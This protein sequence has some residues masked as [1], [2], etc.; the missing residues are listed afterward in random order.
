M[1]QTPVL[2]PQLENQPLQGHWTYEDY[3]NLPDDGRRYEIIDGVLYVTNAP[4]RDHQYTVVRL[5]YQLLQFVESRG[6]GEILTA[7]FEVHLSERS[8][9]VQPDVLFIRAERWPTVGANFFEGAPDLVVEVLSPGSR[10][11]D[12]FIK[13]NAYE[14][15]GVSEYWIV[16]PTGRSVQVWSLAEGEYALV[17]EFMGDE[18]IR[19]VVLEGLEIV[20]STLFNPVSQ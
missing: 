2:P 16:S 15:A 13:S 12:L 18:P 17:G 11:T 4:N 20:A 5:I 7:P 6:L 9:P 8:R 3:L 19:S 14:Q 10:R 1:A